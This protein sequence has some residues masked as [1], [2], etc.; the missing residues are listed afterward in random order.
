MRPLKVRDQP[1]LE[2][3]MSVL[4]SKGYDGFSLNELAK[5]SGLQ[6]ASLYHRFPGGKKEITVAV[7]NHANAWVYEHIFLLLSDQ[8]LAPDE[9]LSKVINNIILLYNGGQEVCILRALSMD[10]GIDLF[11]QEIKESMQHWIQGFTVLG[12]AF[13]HSEN[14]AQKK[15]V[16]ILISIQG[17][18]IVSRGLGTTD[19]FESTLK[20]IKDTYK[21]T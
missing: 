11:D 17:S 15:A 19:A 18:L 1:L 12:R 20:S 3:L 6:K 21:E 5:S 14:V 13:G 8:S 2:R 9:R 16:Q 7:L 4:R 10:T